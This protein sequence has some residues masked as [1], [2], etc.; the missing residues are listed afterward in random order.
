MDAK[1]GKEW[2]LETDAQEATGLTP[3][4]QALRGE[5]DAS[6]LNQLRSQGRGD[7][8]DWLRGQLAF[9]LGLADALGRSPAASFRAKS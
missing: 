4:M 6:E 7:V 1:Q 9:P 8:R 5:W 3:C 2:G